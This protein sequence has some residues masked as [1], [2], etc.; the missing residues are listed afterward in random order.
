MILDSGLKLLPRFLN[1][2]TRDPDRRSVIYPV[3]LT[4][5]PCSDCS[6]RACKYPRCQQDSHRRGDLLTDLSKKAYSRTIHPVGPTGSIGTDSNHSE[7]SNL[8]P[9]ATARFPYTP[10]PLSHQISCT[11]PPPR[12]IT[13]NGGNAAQ[14]KHAKDNT[15]PLPAIPV[16]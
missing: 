12:L 7:R 1:T 16:V 14:S 13:N 10:C 9:N 15:D 4:S 8:P 6:T 2:N 5:A 3:E 11:S